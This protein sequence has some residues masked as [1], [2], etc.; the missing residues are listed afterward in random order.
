M[1]RRSILPRTLVTFASALLLA[2]CSGAQ[3]PPE[4]P[5][6]K[7][8]PEEPL[9]PPDPRYQALPTPSDAPTWAPPVAHLSTLKNGLSLWQME[10]KA[11]PLVSIHLVLPVGSASDPQGKEGLTL[12]AA[13]LLDEGAGNLSALELSDRLGTLA[14]D[15]SSKAGVDYVLLSM[16]ALAE[17]FEE[18]LAL[19]GEIV[20]KPTLAREEFERRKKH[21]LASA[22]SSQDDPEASRSRA[23]SRVLFGN[24]Y[25]GLP[26]EGTL[27]TLEAITYQDVRA[28]VTKMAKPQGAHLM[29]AGMVDQER[30]VRA[31]EK[32]FGS[33]TG[34]PAQVSIQVNPPPAG[35]VAYLIPFEGATQSTL[36][37]ALRSPGDDS[38]PF[39]TEEVM[40][41]K[42]GA[43]FTGRINMNLREDKGYTYRAF[44]TYR[45]YKKAGYY[46]VL[47]DVKTET[48]ALSVTEILKELSAP[49]ADKPLSSE[50]R[51]EAVA[52]LLLGFPLNFD[53]VS[54]MGLRLA[55][56]PIHD[57]SPDY[58]TKWPEEIRGIKTESLNEAVKSLCNTDAYTIV[59][60]GDRAATEEPLSRL[61]WKVV[62]LDRDGNPETSSLEKAEQ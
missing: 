49:C 29:V 6:E 30:A 43:S 27:T 53:E 32:T 12:L 48:T 50:E 8:T 51:D 31:A 33:W 62:L 11:A 17:N 44:A 56:L 5:T 28:Q 16:D 54:S 18:S 23:L 52:G 45:R 7:A 38:G 9:P 36:A 4:I 58:W 25:A 3:P 13:D 19:L 55:S 59:V 24:G 39:F 20:R 47:S 21:H 26:T 61:G 34:K 42:I 14:T 10:S 57:R 40:N 46:A 60:A 37:V 22:L 1:T 15:Y 35:K 41:E 2:A